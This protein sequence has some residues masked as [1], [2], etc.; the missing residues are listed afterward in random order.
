VVKVIAHEGRETGSA[1]SRRL[2]RGGQ[3]P[4][5]LYGEGGTVKILSF[6]AHDFEVALGH[7][8]VPGILIDVQVDKKTQLVK[9]QEVQRHPVKRYVSHVDLL[10]VSSKEV[11]EVSVELEADSDEIRLKEPSLILRGKANAL[12]STLTVPASLVDEG[13]VLAGALPLPKGVELVSDPMT[14]VADAVER[15]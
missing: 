15:E 5:V 7:R 9:L 2:R 14:V 3:I 10:A 12:P 4:A 1:A 6:N 8:V 11:I 13:T